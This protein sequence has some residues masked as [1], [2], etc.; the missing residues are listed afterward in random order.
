[1]GLLK[2]AHSDPNHD[3]I[4]AENE[5]EQSGKNHNNNNTNSQTTDKKS[6][7]SNSI[8]KRPSNASG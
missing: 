6:S 8:S 3:F 7:K 5:K 4:G 1:M 2:A